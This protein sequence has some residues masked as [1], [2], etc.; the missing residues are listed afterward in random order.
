VLNGINRRGLSLFPR[1]LGYL[2]VQSGHSAGQRRQLLGALIVDEAAPGAIPAVPGRLER[3]AQTRL[4]QGVT[5]QRAEL[6]GTMGELAHVPVP[7]VPREG[8]LAT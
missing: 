2:Q 1:G 7:A 5:D 4:V 6:P 8:E 3:L